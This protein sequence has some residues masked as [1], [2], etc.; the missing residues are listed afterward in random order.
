MKYLDRRVDSKWEGRLKEGIL[1]GIEY[2]PEPIS[3]TRP[4]T[5]H[6]YTPDWKVPM[7]K[8]V[9]YIEAKGRFRTMEETKKYLHIRMALRP[10]VE[11][12][13]FLFQN[14]DLALPHAKVRKDG[15]K[16]SHR[17]WAAANGF[18]WFSEYNIAFLLAGKV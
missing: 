6:K 7:G 2:H 9:Y 15:S 3:Y 4:S 10:Q 14:P 11:E 1:R 18:K 13:V 8:K 12:L 16:R 17:E 5:S